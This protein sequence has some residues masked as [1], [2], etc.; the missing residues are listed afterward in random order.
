MNKTLLFSETQKFRQWWVWV[1]LI[2]LNGIILYGIYHQLLLDQQF[3]DKPMSDFGLI[4][5]GIFILLFS[6]LFHFFKL[7][8]LVKEDGIYVRFFPLHKSFRFYS[9][10]KISDFYIRQYSPIGE[11]GGWGL[12]GFGKNRALNVA[13]NIGLQLEFKD[14]KKLLIGTNNSLELNKTILK[15]KAIK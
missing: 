7:E 10:D 14:G 13:G 5:T 4:I 8:T 9:W 2:G 3:G 12:R 15:I 6:V 11:Y 1:L